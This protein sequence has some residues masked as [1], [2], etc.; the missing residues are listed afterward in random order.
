MSLWA[1]QTDLTQGELA[2]SQR[3]GYGGS[4][5][6]LTSSHWK[7]WRCVFNWRT[8]WKVL[9]FLFIWINTHPIL[10]PWKQF[11]HIFFT[12]DVFFFVLIPKSSKMKLPGYYVCTELNALCD[13]IP[14]RLVG[15]KKSGNF[16]FLFTGREGKKNRNVTD[17][18]DCLKWSKIVAGDSEQT[19]TALCCCACCFPS[20]PS[21]VEIS[22]LFHVSFPTKL[23]FISD[24]QLFPFF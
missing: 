15:A 2:E 4:S 3:T 5:T 23:F 21:L 20:V 19:T 17:I 18:F 16:L 14:S 10:V 1:L 11:Q 22:L 9:R 8:V 24:F 7:L 6:I 12:T 13:L